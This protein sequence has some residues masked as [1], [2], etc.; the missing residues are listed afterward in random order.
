MD[1]MYREMLAETVAS[2]ELA[3]A[4]FYAFLKRYAVQAGELTA[5]YV[6]TGWM[7]LLR[8]ADSDLNFSERMDEAMIADDA[9]RTA[10]TTLESAPFYGR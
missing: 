9:W 5:G 10:L 6:E 2:A 8:A 7:A 1:Q 3:R 4:E